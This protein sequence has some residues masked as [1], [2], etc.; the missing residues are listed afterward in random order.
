MATKT[1]KKFEMAFD[2]FKKP[3]KYTMG[4]TQTVI[5]PNGKSKYFDDREYYSGRGKKYNSTVRHDDVGEVKVSRKQYK[6]FLDMMR[7]REKNRLLAEQRQR[8]KNQRIEDARAR[9]VYD[10]IENGH[11]GH[12]VELS[13]EESD[14][15][16]F[17][18]Q[19]LAK[20]LDISV[21]DAELL[22]AGGKTYVFARQKG[23]GKILELYHASL[24]CNPL[25]IW[26]TEVTEERVKEFNHSKWL[27]SPYGRALGQTENKNHFVC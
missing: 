11:G 23:T 4:G 24:S 12:W 22:K 27:N 2:Y 15:R 9:G 8:E 25:N 20:T 14:G 1:Q 16:F 18:A 21:E 3:Y 10:L 13:G 26:V 17:D 7:E 6:N 5:L 19:R